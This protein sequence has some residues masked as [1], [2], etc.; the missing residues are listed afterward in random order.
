MKQE[1]Q[2]IIQAAQS[3]SLLSQDVTF[4]GEEFTIKVY[5]NDQANLA[6]ETPSRCETV[7]T[8]RHR[9]SI[10]TLIYVCKQRAPTA[11]GKNLQWQPSLTKFYSYVG[12]IGKNLTTSDLLHHH[13]TIV[14]LAIKIATALDEN[15]LPNT[16]AQAWHDS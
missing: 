2:N 15:F 13:S 7:V 16:T 5:Q 3:K 4:N 6:L 1:I 8:V 11:N 9:G 14:P 10:R 12:H